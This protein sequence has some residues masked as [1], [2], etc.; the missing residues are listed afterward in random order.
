MDVI[1]SLRLDEEEIVN[2]ISDNTNLQTSNTS[3]ENRINDD[4]KVAD[5]S[6]EEKAKMDK[7]L[8]KDDESVTKGTLEKK[9]VDAYLNTVELRALEQMR[10]HESKWLTA[11]KAEFERTGVLP[12]QNYHDL[13]PEFRKK[14][15][16]KEQE[17][18]KKLEDFRLE[19]LLGDR[20]S[21]GKKRHLEFSTPEETYKDESASNDKGGSASND[22]DQSASN[23]KDASSL[24]D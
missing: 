17:L 22:K 13:V 11:E 1:S 18:I 24:K 16:I 12:E 9:Y 20:G 4:N 15:G 23:D 5:N 2:S 3:T 7:A 19:E 10:I 6:N 8:D 14:D 21:S